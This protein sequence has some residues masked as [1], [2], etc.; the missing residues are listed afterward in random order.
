MSIPRSSDEQTDTECV[1]AIL[2]GS[3]QALQDVLLAC[4]PALKRLCR[5]Y[6]HARMEFDD[7]TQEVCLLLFE[8]DKHVLRQFKGYNAAG[9]HCRLKTFV[10]TCAARLLHKKNTKALSESGAL[11]S[12]A[13]HEGSCIHVP[14]SSASPS[15]QRCEILDLLLKLPSPRERL[16]V[17]EYV[18][19]ER[20]PHEIAQIL[21][22]TTASVYTLCSRALRRL[23]TILAEGE[24]FHV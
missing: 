8:N 3:S 11:L 13:D 4:A 9:R 15:Y 1:N 23:K 14:D 12:L 21:G 10:I 22:V 6:T 19:N 7:I 2:Q 24:R 16:V 17:A 20:P 5:T 18:F